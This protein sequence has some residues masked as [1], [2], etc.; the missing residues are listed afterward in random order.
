M[1]RHFKAR[2]ANTDLWLSSAP[3]RGD[4]APFTELT[5]PPACAGARL[6]AA[7]V[8]G[9]SLAASFTPANT[10]SRPDR[11]KDREKAAYRLLH[12]SK[13]QVTTCFAGFCRATAN[14]DTSLQSINV[15]AVRPT[16]IR[17]QNRPQRDVASYAGAGGRTE[18]PGRRTC[19]T[20]R[21][22]SGAWSLGKLNHAVHTNDWRDS[23]SHAA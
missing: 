11:A 18:R 9:A 4:A 17:D 7:S 14:A 1:V 2:E 12:G 19:H 5:S 21:A 20:Q 6:T 13:Q 15:S 3:G 23:V 10:G 22:P 16:M 8:R